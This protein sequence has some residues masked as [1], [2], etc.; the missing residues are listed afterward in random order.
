MNRE[1]LKAWYQASRPPFFIATLIPLILGARIAALDGHFNSLLFAVVIL[2][3]FFVHLNTN[4]T[5]DYFEYENDS[6]DLAIGGSRGLQNG[7]ISMAQMKR[8]III[9]YILAFLAGL[10]ILF[11]THCMAILLLATFAFLSSLFYTAPPLRLGYRGLGEITVGINMGPVMVLG[12]YLVMLQ[13]FSAKALLLSLPIGIMV[14]MI[15]FYQSLPDMNADEAIG[16]RTLAVRS[17]RKGSVII[18]NAA[19]AS[20]YFFVMYFVSQGLL[21]YTA[22]ASI[23]TFPFITQTT[24]L[25][26]NSED[27]IPLHEKGHLVRLFYLI[28]G[29]IIILT[30]Q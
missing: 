4:L 20:V 24:R 17:G 16:K 26:I 22:L 2:A 28:N 13:H 15:L 12:T 30:V 27:W 1:T 25:L 29:L 10:Y 9:F 19:A 6:R 3:S 14:A 7:L 5:N 23:I 8:V 11:V 18:L 21:S